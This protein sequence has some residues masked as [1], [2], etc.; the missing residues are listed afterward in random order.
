MLH[1]LILLVTLTVSTTATAQQ[2]G[3]TEVAPGVRVIDGVKVEVLTISGEAIKAAIKADPKFSGIK[4][5]LGSEGITNPGPSGSVTHMYKL[6]DTDDDA[7]KVLI[8][9]VKGG[10]IVDLLLT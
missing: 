1:A 4:N 5:M 8:L 7:D 10:K 2:A 3:G 9:F 6:R